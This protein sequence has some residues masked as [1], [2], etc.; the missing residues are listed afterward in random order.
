MV[1]KQILNPVASVFKK[2]VRN[3]N[4]K[5]IDSN[6]NLS[7]LNSRWDSMNRIST[8]LQKKLISNSLIDEIKVFRI[9]HSEPTDQ[10]LLNHV[11]D[12]SHF[13]ILGLGNWGACTAWSCHDGT[14]I[15]NKGV[16]TILLI[17]EAFKD[18]ALATLDS[19]GI[20]DLPIYIFPH[21]T[22]LMGIEELD[23]FVEDAVNSKIIP[24]IK[25]T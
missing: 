13:A 20:P 10:N 9:N 24:L 2:Y 3:V 4:F 5:K 22:E 25:E 23:P 7:I 19:R 8:L 21:E 12:W 16:S 17:T 6:L 15:A 14:E 1:K 11:T 18:L